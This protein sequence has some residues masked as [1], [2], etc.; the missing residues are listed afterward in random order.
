MWGEILSQKEKMFSAK[1]VASDRPH[2]EQHSRPTATSSAQHLFPRV[3]TRAFVPP[4]SCPA[5]ETTKG[6]TVTARQAAAVLGLGTRP[7][8]S[9]QHQ[10]YVLRGWLEDRVQLASLWRTADHTW[11]RETGHAQNHCGPAVERHGEGRRGVGEG[12]WA[13][14]RAAGCGG[15]GRNRTVSGDVGPFR[16]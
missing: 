1:N 14:D 3:K 12:K 9:G 5:R 11:P 8:R 4:N 10:Q 7:R 13:I 2:D 6:E 15:G 16:A